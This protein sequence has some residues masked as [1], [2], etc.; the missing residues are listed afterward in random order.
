[1]ASYIFDEA[2]FV[3]GMY[4]GM[5]APLGSTQVPPPPNAAKPLRF[6]NGAW[7]LEPSAPEAHISLLAFYNRFTS[8]ER[9]LVKLARANDM[10]VDDFMMLVGAAKYIDLNNQDTKNGVAYL[11]YK[12]LLTT[13]RATAILGAPIADAERP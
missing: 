12:D 9:I 2:G 3:A 11:V 1:M 6:L 5:G 13:T 4:D 8:P 10:I 7:V